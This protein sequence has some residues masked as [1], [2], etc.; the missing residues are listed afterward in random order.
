MGIG[1]YPTIDGGTDDGY[2]KGHYLRAVQRERGKEKK[3][4]NTFD[5]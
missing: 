3:G 4:S 1:L 5:A 2:R